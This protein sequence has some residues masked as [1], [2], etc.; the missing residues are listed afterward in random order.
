MHSAVNPTSASSSLNPTVFSFHSYDSAEMPSDAADAMLGSTPRCEG[1]AR[2]SPEVGIAHKEKQS[3]N[4]NPDVVS[5]HRESL[6]S[7]YIMKSK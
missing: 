7:Q 5:L 3:T 1:G 6:N 4:S 2:C